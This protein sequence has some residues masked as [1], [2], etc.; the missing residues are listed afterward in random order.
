M[1]KKWVILDE[2]GHF[3]TPSE[4]KISKEV[5]IIGAGILTEKYPS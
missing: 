3:C 5:P 2:N 1:G 4:G